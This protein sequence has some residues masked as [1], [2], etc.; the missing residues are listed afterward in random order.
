MDHG[1]KT[2]TFCGTAEYLAPE[3][4]STRH[5]DAD[6][7]TRAVDWWTVGVVLH[8]MLVGRLPFAAKS[9]ND[10]RT[11][12]ERIINEELRLPYELSHESKS[13]LTQL[14]EK[15]PSKRLGSSVNDF[16]DVKKHSFFYKI[17]WTKLINKQ[18]EPPFKPQVTSD[19]DT[20]YFEEEFTGENVQLTPP[21]ANSR[22]EITNEINYFDSFSFYGSKSSLNSQKSH[23]S[24]KIKIQGLTNNNEKF[25]TFSLISDSP[26]SITK[27]DSKLSLNNHDSVY[28]A[29][30]AFPNIIQFTDNNGDLF[31]SKAYF[32]DSPSYDYANMNKSASI[33]SSSSS[34]SNINSLNNHKH[35]KHDLPV[36]SLNNFNYKYLLSNNA[37]SNSYRESN[38]C[39]M[40]E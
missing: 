33:S 22:L 24:M 6:G 30:N 28:L 16:E 8:E 31:Q 13:I 18:I 3:V 12:Y 4:I 39:K 25:D 11:L 10:H 9:Q 14:L 5:N 37:S 7:Y 26:H 32:T 40:D 19:T 21:D 15:M 2:N 38:E 36:I 17:D 35:E 1:S 34:S 23:S 27:S 20:R 29:S